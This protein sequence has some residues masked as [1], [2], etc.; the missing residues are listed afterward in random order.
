MAKAPSCPAPTPLMTRAWG[1]QSSAGKRTADRVA[2]HCDSVVVRVVSGASFNVARAPGALER[3][4]CGI[5]TRDIRGHGSA[6]AAGQ[7]LKFPVSLLS[8][9]FEPYERLR[10]A[11]VSLRGDEWRPFSSLRC[12]WP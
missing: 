2:C 11:T 3:A 9:V 10:S 12:R 6:R 1:L 4:R 5:S 8:E 7:G